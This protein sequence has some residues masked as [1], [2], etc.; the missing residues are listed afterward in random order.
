[1][2]SVFRAL[3]LFYK[4]YVSSSIQA[5]CRYTPTCSMYMLD[6]IEK[7]GAIKGV[8]LGVGRLLRCNHFAKGGFDPVKENIRGIAKW[9]L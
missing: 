6:A 9:T 1:M 3:I 7:Y 8:G 2:K 5:R 4:R